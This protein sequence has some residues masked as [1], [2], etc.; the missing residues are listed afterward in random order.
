MYLIAILGINDFA[1]LSFKCHAQFI[2]GWPTTFTVYMLLS[3]RYSSFLV[4]LFPVMAFSCPFK[5]PLGSVFSASTSNTSLPALQCQLG[6]AA[7]CGQKQ[8]AG[9]GADGSRGGAV[10]R[11]WS[12]SSLG[13]AWCPSLLRWAANSVF[14]RILPPLHWGHMYLQWDSKFLKKCFCEKLATISLKSLSFPFCCVSE[15]H[16]A[17]MNNF[18]SEEF[19]CHFLKNG[20]TAKTFWTKK[21]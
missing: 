14:I 11:L 5:V 21:D 4:F 18:S 15:R 1:C 13:P 8:A 17:T 7:L 9:W 19:D 20:F 10:G 6:L 16:Q 12:G 3:V 2:D